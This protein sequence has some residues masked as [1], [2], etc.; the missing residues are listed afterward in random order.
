MS[1]LRRSLL[2]VAIVALLIALIPA[3]ALAQEITTGDDGVIIRINGP[4][5]I[6]AGETVE[7]VVVISGDATID[8]TL[9]G[10][11]VVIDGDALVSGQV[12]D[13]VTVVSGTLDLASTA[14]VENVSIIRGELV[15]DASASIGGSI[16]QGDYQV[17]PWDWGIFW[18][19]MWVGMTLVVLTSGVIL[20]AIGGRQVKA[21]GDAIQRDIGPSLLGAV[22]AW[23]VLPVLMFMVLFT[24]IGIPIGVGYFLFVLPVLWFVGY[25]AAGTHLGRILLSR[26]HDDEHPYLPALLGLMILQVIGIVPVIGGMLGFLAGIIG[27][28]ALLVLGWRAWRGPSATVVAPQP[29]PVTP[30]PVP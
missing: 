14:Q 28:G 8:G 13:D 30:A 20:A 22:V 29:G 21:A 15:R 6:A 1:Q 19:F 2:F 16:S 18:A 12:R 17:S 27:S 7:T 25:I 5:H 10:S 11:L 23:L 9:M 24:V 4:V 26:R 3:A